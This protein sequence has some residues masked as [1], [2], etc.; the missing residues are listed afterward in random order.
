MTS[1]WL[2]FPWAHTPVPH[3][4]VMCNPGVISE[5][6]A[7]DAIVHT[8]N[9]IGT[10]N[11][12][13]KLMLMMSGGQKSELIF[14]TSLDTDVDIEPIFLIMHDNLNHHEFAQLEKIDALYSRNNSTKENP[15]TQKAWLRVS[16]WLTGKTSPSWPELVTKHGFTDIRSG[17]LAWL[18]HA[19]CDHYGDDVCVITGLGD[20]PVTWV[21]DS[22]VAGQSYWSLCYR[23]GEHLAYRD[24]I[25]KHFPGDVPW[26]WS[27]TPEMVLSILSDPHYQARMKKSRKM[28]LGQS[29]LNEVI[30][31]NFPHIECR[32]SYYGT[33]QFTSD[34][35]DI[36]KNIPHTEL[37]DTMD[38]PRQIP[39]PYV[40]T[41]Y[42]E[43]I[44]LL[45]QNTQN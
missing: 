44:K 9:T 33:E 7:Y 38:Q 25:H 22:K 29:A 31:N 30:S 27:H 2:T 17:M 3:R 32:D 40:I 26:F 21:A 1:D 10:Q 35:T 18:R 20:I 19:I 28:N 42:H 23:H 34:I 16:D 4:E 24:Y 41:E 13:R 12:G 36:I 14:R 43:F 6:S 37:H 45:Q 39:E 5:L 8:I 15:S 11:P